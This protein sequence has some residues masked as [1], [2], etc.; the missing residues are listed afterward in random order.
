MQSMSP[1]PLIYF[2]DIDGT[3]VG[4]VLSQVA[5]WDILTKYEKGKI[6]QFRRNLMTQLQNGLLRP[7]FTSFIDSIKSRNESCE[8]HVYTASETK[9]AHFLIGC[10][11]QVI[12]MKFSRPLFTRNHCIKTSKEYQKSLQLVGNIVLKKQSPKRFKHVKELVS[13][14]ILI[15]NNKVLIKA[16]DS[17]LLQLCPT[18]MFKDVYDV[19]RL[20]SEQTMHDN[21]MEIATS[22]TMHGMFPVL[23]TPRVYSYHVFKSLY[24]TFLGSQI[25]ENIKTLRLIKDD[26]WLK[27]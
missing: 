15:D 25:K 13:R 7:H 21:F 23:D 12:G 9:W 17:R 24:F 6:P 2:F 5:E 16:E 14:S 11:E 27:A 26:F 4:D 19:L 8:F 3:M 1:S 20:V 22:L 10:V 18:Y